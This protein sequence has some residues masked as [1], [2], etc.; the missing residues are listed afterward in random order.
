MKPSA[1]AVFLAAC[2][3]IV[4]QA[5]QGQRIV[6]L[7]HF[8]PDSSPRHYPA[9]YWVEGAAIGASLLG[10]TGAWLGAGF[11]DSSDCGG[12]AVTGALIFG[13]VGGMAGALFGGMVNA[14]HPRPLRGH[15]AKAALVGTIAGAMW[16]F[17]LF[18]HFCADGCNPSEVRFGISTAAVGALAGLVMGL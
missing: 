9:T 12:A 8:P 2:L 15:P 13:A 4:P 18:T 14:P 11:C 1:L 16:G 3:V 6:S 10:T 17:G 7:G 5:S